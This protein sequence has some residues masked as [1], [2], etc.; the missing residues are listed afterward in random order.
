MRHAH[1]RHLR[2]TL[3]AYGTRE[4]FEWSANGDSLRELEPAE[5]IQRE[6][7]QFWTVPRSLILAAFVAVV[8]AHHI[9]WS[10]KL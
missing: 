10:A 9:P 6:P 7:E 4:H 2:C 8:I 3:P 1:T 5:H